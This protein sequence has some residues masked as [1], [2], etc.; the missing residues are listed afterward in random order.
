MLET[1]GCADSPK[2]F[3]RVSTAAPPKP[4]LRLGSPPA[5]RWPEAVLPGPLPKTLRRRNKG[6]HYHH[7]F[8]RGHLV[9][10][11]VL[12]DKHSPKTGDLP[13]QVVL[14]RPKLKAK[15]GLERT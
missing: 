13:F 8:I 10:A 4:G 14:G 7:D 5:R 1:K 15:I 11:H 6:T 12:P 3:A 9:K 2:A